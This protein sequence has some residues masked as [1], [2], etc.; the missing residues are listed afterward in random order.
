MASDTDASGSGGSC[1]RGGA[2]WHPANRPR[3]RTTRTSARR[4][5]RAPAVRP[6]EAHVALTPPVHARPVAG[7]VVRAH[8][9]LGRAVLAEPALGA[10]AAAARAL[11]VAGAV[12]RA[13]VGVRLDRA[14]VGGPPRLAEAAPRL[15]E[16]VVGA[17]V[18]ARDRGAA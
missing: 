3:S 7:A 17:V 4:R 18:G 2:S 13:L 9:R 8:G 6:A 14:V 10:H 16:P 5:H 1:A 15:A 11:A 12:V